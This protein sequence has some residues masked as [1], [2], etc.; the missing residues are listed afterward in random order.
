MLCRV[1]V[2]ETNCAAGRVVTNIAVHP[3]LSPWQ[4]GFL[5]TVSGVCGYRLCEPAS[6]S[7]YTEKHV[8]VQQGDVCRGWVRWGCD[9][10]GGKTGWG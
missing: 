8:S 4:T 5:V 3:L 7:N 9:G 2:G 6:G 10:G 1:T